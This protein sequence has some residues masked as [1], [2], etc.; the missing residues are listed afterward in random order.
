MTL[1]E[2]RANRERHR[3]GLVLTCIEDHL[4]GKR[5]PLSLVTADATLYAPEIKR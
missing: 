1:P 2:L 3:S 4:A 5:Y